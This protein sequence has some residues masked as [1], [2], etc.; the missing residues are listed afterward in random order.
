MGR[1]V[2]VGRLFVRQ[3]D[4]E[5][6]R[7]GARIGR[8]PVGRFH[9]R[10]AAA[11]TDHELPP[12]FL[13]DRAARGDEGKLACFLVIL[14]LG[15]QPFDHRLLFGRGGGGERG[16]DHVGRGNPGRAIDHQRRADVGLIE[17]HFGLQ[18]FE[19]EAHRAQFLAQ[20]EVGVAKREA[21]GRALLLR[22]G[23]R[24]RFDE[25]GFLLGL[26]EAV[27]GQIAGILVVCHA[28]NLS[29]RAVAD[30]ILSSTPDTIRRACCTALTLCRI[31]E[32]TER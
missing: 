15:H 14:G 22:R 16:I 4:V 8:A 27:I 17:Q 1:D 31:C 32:T 6:D 25:A 21:V 28:R 19:L 2:R 30:A 12:P 7:F 18:Q 5:P 24:L 3:H 20:Q 13:H 29:P 23:A 26:V 11:R 10:R 9:D